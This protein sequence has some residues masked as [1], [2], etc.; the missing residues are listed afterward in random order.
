MIVQ[1][2]T[3]SSSG[4]ILYAA[5]ISLPEFLASLL[6]KKHANALKLPSSLSRAR[7]AFTSYTRLAYTPCLFRQL[8]LFFARRQ[9]VLCKEG[10]TGTDMIIPLLLEDGSF[11]FILLQVKNVESQRDKE[12]P[13]S[14][15]FKLAKSYVFEDTNLGKS[16]KPYLSIYW[17]VHAP[18]TT[19][20]LSVCTN[21]LSVRGCW[22]CDF[23]AHAALCLAIVLSTPFAL[24]RLP[25]FFCI[26]RRKQS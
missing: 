24:I 15:T 7:V 14:A 16:D 10:Q 17:Q 19:I 8:R 2:S 4:P 5:G 3:V 6:G 21:P 20:L 25:G 11:S 26:F 9:A 1:N 18:E 22:E 12:Y 23:F 13:E